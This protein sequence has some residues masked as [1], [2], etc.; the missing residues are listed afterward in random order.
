MRRTV[1]PE[2]NMLRACLAAPVVAPIAT[3]LIGVLANPDTFV[4]GMVGQ[5]Q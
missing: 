2:V 4:E 3:L 1:L 5:A